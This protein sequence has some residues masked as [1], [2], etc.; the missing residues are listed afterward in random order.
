[1]TR[2]KLIVFE[3][4]DGSGKATQVNL[5]T[6]TLSSRSIAHTIIDFPRYGQ[7]FFGDLA[8]K[9]LKG[10]F[11]GINAVPPELA[12]FPFACDRWLIKKD[13]RTWLDE[14][15][16]VLAN[17]YTA[18]SAVYQAAKLPSEKQQ[19]F[20]H[21]VYTLEQDII[22]LPKEDI[23]FYL[24]VPVVMAQQLIEKKDARAYLGDKKK[25]IYE[26]DVTLQ[27]TVE[28]LYLSLATTQSNW[29][30]VECIKDGTIRPPS[31]IQNDIRAVLAANGVL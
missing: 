31:D 18:S 30:T 27:E 29:K 9:M 12:V 22:G 28:R 3:G 5:L 19:K 2:G 20:I 6:E 17:R 14:G 26:E 25:D 4:T 13:I 15:T 11:G 21:W 7:S 23:V 16:T 8:G 10:D 24:H 1:M